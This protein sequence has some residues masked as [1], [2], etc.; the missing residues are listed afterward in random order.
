MKSLASDQD[1]ADAAEVYGRQHGTAFFFNQEDANSFLDHM[2]KRAKGR[3]ET[4]FKGFADGIGG[5][6]K[7]KYRYMREAAAPVNVYDVE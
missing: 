1:C 5:K 6:F 2:E 3:F 4:Y 7:R